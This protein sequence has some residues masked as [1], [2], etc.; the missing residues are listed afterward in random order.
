[1]ENGLEFLEVQRKCVILIGVA[2][3]EPATLSLFEMCSWL[4]LLEYVS[5]RIE[6]MVRKHRSCVKLGVYLILIY[7]CFKIS[8]II[9]GLGLVFFKFRL[10]ISLNVI[11]VCVVAKF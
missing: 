10:I 11:C 4:I 2:D 1:M 7:S 9:L 8:F 5:I 3:I 6:V